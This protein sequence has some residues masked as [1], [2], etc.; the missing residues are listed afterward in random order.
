ML[1]THT[2]AHAHT[3]THLCRTQFFTHAHNSFS[4][5]LFHTQLFHIQFFQVLSHTHNFVTHSSFTPHTQTRRLRDPSVPPELVRHLPHKRDV[6]VTKRHACHTKVKLMSP[7]TDTR[8]Q[9]RHQS[10]PSAV[11]AT[12]AT[13]KH[14]RS[15]CHHMPRH[16]KGAKMDQ[17][18]HRSQPSAVRAT[19][20]TQ[21]NHRCY[22][23]PPATQ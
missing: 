12:P 14:R 20:A 22:Q 9:S 8:A 11:S 5:H 2:R 18:R 4:R 3:H 17:A 19:P 1:H 16:E 10:Q 21:K 15:R 13:Q 7:P 23:M 6:D